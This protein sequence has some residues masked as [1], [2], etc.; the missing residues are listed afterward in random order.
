MGAVLP[1]HGTA[2]FQCDIGQWADAYAFAAGYARIG[3]SKFFRVYEKRVESTV[4]NAAAQLI[5]Q[6]IRGRPI[7][8]AVMDELR[9]LINGLFG[10]PQDRFCR[11]F[12]RR[13]KQGDIVF[14]HNY[15]KAAHAAQP[16]SRAELF[17]IDSGTADVFAAGHDKP[18]IPISGERRLFQ[19]FLHKAGNPPGIGGGDHHPRLIGMQRGKILTAQPLKQI[20]HFIVQCF[21]DSGG[22]IRAVAGARKVNNHKIL[23]FPQRGVLY[24]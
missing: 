15:R 3:N 14:R 23:P 1:P 16:F 8:L 2:V 10:P 9:G 11:F 17:R 22:G 19:P 7:S 18:D 4:D 12:I 5:E 13:L 20:Q 6:R 24:H 21:A